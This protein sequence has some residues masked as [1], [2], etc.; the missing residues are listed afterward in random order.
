MGSLLN[1]KKEASSYRKSSF[2]KSKGERLGWSNLNEEKPTLLK[3]VLG[4]G[5]IVQEPSCLATSAYK[6]ILV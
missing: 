3:A 2:A 4:R 1:N 6:K 5:E